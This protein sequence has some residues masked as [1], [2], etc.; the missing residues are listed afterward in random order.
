MSGDG[1]VLQCGVCH[2]SKTLGLLRLLYSVTTELYPK[3]TLLKKD[4][5]ENLRL[6]VIVLDT[7]YSFFP[8]RP[9]TDDSVLYIVVLT[10]TNPSNVGYH[11]LFHHVAYTAPTEAS[12]LV[13]M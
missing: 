7:T 13:R 4:L 8:C 2:G 1:C 12:T 11:Y 9:N 6:V 3:I 10:K 5:S